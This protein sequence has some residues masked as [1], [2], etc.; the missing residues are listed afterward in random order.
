MEGLALSDDP[1]RRAALR[2]A[3]A[4]FERYGYRKTSMEDVA[5]EI[6][7]SRQGLYLWYPSKKALFSAVLDEWLRTQ[8][9]AVEGA[10]RS[11]S[12]PQEA[13]V[14]ALDSLH[15]RYLEQPSS[16][17]DE[18]LEAAAPLIGDRWVELMDWVAGELAER[19][20]EPSLERAKLLLAASLGTKHQGSTH[21]AYL[22][23]M[24]LA[25]RLLS[26]DS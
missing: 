11:H 15:G 7:V 12:S 23:R 17:R 5:Q 13:L 19:L 16:T 10:L 25:V 22:E 4:V 9:E 20:P 8:R 3:L 26:Q 21:A 6:G 14:Q 18:L 24:T 1:S 2:S